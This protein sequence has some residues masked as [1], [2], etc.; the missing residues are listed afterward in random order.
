LDPATLPWPM[1]AWM[2]PAA[3]QSA[4]LHGTA[5]ALAAAICE[6]AYRFWDARSHTHGHTLPGISCEFWPPDGR[7]GGEGYGWGAFTAHLLL[8]V[9]LGLAPDQNV[10]RLRPNLP[11]QWRGAGER[12]GVRL[13]WRERII[14][15]ELV[16][17]QSGVLVRA[18]RQSAEVM[19]G[20]ELVYRLEDL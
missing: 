17:A 14:T 2:A 15:I 10:L 1:G 12:Y 6:R 4:G 13:Q 20:D 18:N 8:H 3:A 19:W 11:V 5:A 7:C 9:I 16:P